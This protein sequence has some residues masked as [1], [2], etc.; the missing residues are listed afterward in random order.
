MTAEITETPTNSAPFVAGDDAVLRIQGLSKHFG[1]A[2][3]GRRKSTLVKAVDDVSFDLAPGETLG[4]VGESGCGKTTLSRMILR[5]IEPTHGQVIA[6]GED[7]TALHGKDLRDFR[8]RAQVV[9][10]D[11][12][13]S[14]DPRQKVLSSVAEPLIT[15]GHSTK[16]RNEMAMEVL[17]RIGF[18]TGQAH[19]FPHQFS[20]GQ[21]QRIGIAR[22]L[23]VTPEVLVLD[24]PVSALDVSIQAQVLKLL[25][26]LRTEFGL[27][28]ILISHD[29]SVVRYVSDRVM[30][31]YLGRIVEM[32]DTADLYDNPAHPYTSSLL[33]AAPAPD[34]VVERQ[35]ERIVLAG[36]PP[37][38]ANP[39]SGCSFHE[40][41]AK[42][43]AVASTMPTTEL[44]TIG[45]GR[46]VPRSC[47]S[48]Q[49]ALATS[50]ARKRWVACHFPLTALEPA[51]I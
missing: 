36:D 6:G 8:Q 13:A 50:P 37:N 35:R 10:Q 47:A 20:G 9:F 26:D 17:H 44:H 43:I 7:V 45:D 15:S 48:T 18:T 21:R 40:R 27:S 28:Y 11:P 39:P 24:E 30:V 23:S 22:A 16:K 2:G 49:P 51:T 12:Y 25:E 38:P 1:R 34:P 46:Q 5:L 31:M 19:R 4:L 3:R 42:A 41:C 32:A 14:L 33:S 29:L